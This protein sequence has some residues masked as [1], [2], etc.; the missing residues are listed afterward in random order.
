MFA[1]LTIL[2]LVAERQVSLHEL[3]AERRQKIFCTPELSLS[4]GDFNGAFQKLLS[5]YS[6]TAL[7]TD[8]F[9]GLSFEMPGDWRFSVRRSKTEPVVR[10]NFEARRSPDTMLEEGE[11]VLALL[12]AFKSDEKDWFSGFH[13]A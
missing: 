13:L 7:S 9:D 11:K 4:L 8:H 6:E 5:A 2:G 10:L 1:W 12:E 3:V